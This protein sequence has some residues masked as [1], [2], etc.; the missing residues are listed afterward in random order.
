MLPRA[1][2][3][4][5]VEVAHTRVGPAGRGG[6]ERRLVL[7]HLHVLLEHDGRGEPRAEQLRGRRARRRLRRH[8]RLVHGTHVAGRWREPLQRE[9][10]AAREPLVERRAAPEE[11]ARELQHAHAGHP[12]ADAQRVDGRQGARD[13]QHLLGRVRVRVCCLRRGRRLVHRLNRRRRRRRR[14]GSRARRVPPRPGRRR[15]WR[16]LL[17]V[18]ARF[19][20]HHAVR[21]H[22]GV[23]MFARVPRGLTHLRVLRRRVHLELQ[24]VARVE[25]VR[26]RRRGLVVLGVRVLADR[27]EVRVGDHRHE[28]VSDAKHTHWRLHRPRFLRRISRCQR[29]GRGHLEHT[30]ERIERSGIHEREAAN[31]AASR[32]HGAGGA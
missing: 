3:I 16:L 10:R 17:A 27:R 9:R 19:G 30:A 4:K 28:R 13:L 11:R 32:R 12:D 6:A 15:T 22:L 7:E 26:R 23:R 18:G 25:R 29:L 8:V 24:L 20:W 31:G 14:S 1:G 21:E 5:K 2:K